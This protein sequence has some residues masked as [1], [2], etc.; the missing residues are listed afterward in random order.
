MLIISDGSAAKSYRSDLLKRSLMHKNDG[1][2]G[3]QTHPKKVPIVH[4]MEAMSTENKSNL[5]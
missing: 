1:G 5:N 4:K 2:M 3:W